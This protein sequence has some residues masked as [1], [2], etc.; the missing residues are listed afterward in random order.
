MR[1]DAFAV[2]ASLNMRT[3]ADAAIIAALEYL[4][5]GTITRQIL[6]D[7]VEASVSEK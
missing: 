4:E 3:F 7:I 2:I 5:K 6:A 1:S